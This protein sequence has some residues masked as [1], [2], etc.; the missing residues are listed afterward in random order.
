[1]TLFVV[2]ESP[3]SECVGTPSKVTSSQLK[4]QKRLIFGSEVP[5]RKRPGAL[6]LRGS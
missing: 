6:C 3:A 2:A 1:M 5:H 4:G